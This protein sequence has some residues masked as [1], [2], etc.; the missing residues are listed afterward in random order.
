MIGQ[1]LG[2]YRIEA[3]LGSGAMGF[4]YLGINEV[5]HK[6]AAIKVIS[7][8][9]MGKGKGLD[10]FKREATILEQF[11]HPNIVKYMARG[12]SGGTY[13]YAM[14]YIT[15]PT[16]D[17]VIRDRGCL[18]WREV[19]G[20]GIQLCDALHYAHERGVVHRDLK[21]SNLMLTEQGLLKLTDFGIA[22]DLD[23]TALTA[24]GKT[25]GTAAYMAPEQIRG[26]PDI[27]H[28]T[29]LY[30]LGAVMYQMLTGEP[31]FGGTTVIVLMQAHMNEP[32]KR[33]SLKVEEIPK[34]LDDLVIHLMAKA[35]SDRPWDAAAVAQI[36][37]DLQDKESRQETI[38]MV[39]AQPGSAASMPI[40]AEIL[41]PIA[42]KSTKKKKREEASK[43][44]WEV[45]GLVAALVLVAGLMG[46]MLWPVSAGYLYRNAETLM[47]SSNYLDWTKARDEYLEPL[48]RRFPDHPYKEKTETWLDRIDFNVAD[49]KSKVLEQVNLTGFSKPQ[50]EAEALYQNTF[51]E[52]EAAQRLHHDRDA[53][54]HWRK[55]EKL[56]T[57]EG[58]EN[59]GWVLLARAKGD[60]IA[61]QTRL[62]RE[63]VADLLAKAKLPDVIATSSS[64]SYSEK[65]L[66]DIVERFGDYQDVEDLVEQAK[67]ALAPKEPTSD[68]G[69]PATPDK[70]EPPKP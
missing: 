40:R 24:T 61:K 44:R 20:L 12:K 49:R 5:K 59:R 7:A 6:Q 19:V 30:A 15:G 34:V 56:L 13:Y 43:A 38:K 68:V 58:R 8:D 31:P 60:E 50:N 36:L 10:R 57:T 53:E 63:T 67:A 54:Q 2:S 55:M 1:K 21:P 29:D 51:R 23:A 42:K 41:D 32:P 46:Y 45:V 47:A 33:P 27:S 26:T 52:A 16:L 17:K 66:K 39:W 62:R 64:R 3:E 14:E 28:K 25:L 48:G 18:P 11:R 9:Q 65:T 22:K 37:R 4:V 69:T 70:V 35:P